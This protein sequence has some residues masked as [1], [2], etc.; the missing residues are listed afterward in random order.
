MIKVNLVP[1]EILAKAEQKQQM[2]QAAAAGV[3]VLA[4]IALVSMSHYYKLES[5]EKKLAKQQSDLKKLEVIV[6]KVEELERTAAAVRARLNVITDL[7]KSRPLYPY[8]MSDFVRSVPTGVRVKALT[9]AGGGSNAGPIKLNIQAE[10]RTNEDIAEWVRRME[11]M[12]RF[13]ATE[14]GP[15]QTLEGSNIN[16]FTMTSVYTAQL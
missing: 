6:A 16:N 15:V 10:A 1:A 7:L 2:L 4:V 12:G 11:E 3:V 5:I 14:L 8:F 9:T 13:S